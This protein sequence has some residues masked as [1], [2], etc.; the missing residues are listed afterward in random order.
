MTV[1]LAVVNGMV[2]ATGKFRLEPYAPVE[3]SVCTLLMLPLAP[4]VQ[5]FVVSAAASLAV[6]T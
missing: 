3:V 6:N 4:T 5:V 2:M 1:P